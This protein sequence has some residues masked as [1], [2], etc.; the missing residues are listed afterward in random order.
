MGFTL[1]FKDKN[2][3]LQCLYDLDVYIVNTTPGENEY[4]AEIIRST[5]SSNIAQFVFDNIGSQKELDDFK[6]DCAEIDCIR[7][8][9]FMSLHNTKC[10]HVEILRRMD[11]KFL[12]AIE[13]K[14]NNIAKRWNL[15]V[16]K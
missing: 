13:E 8:F 4:Q 14:L 6:K 9:L 3:T 2:G 11:Q 12:P 15:I 1:D 7:Q 10:T 16:R 5:N